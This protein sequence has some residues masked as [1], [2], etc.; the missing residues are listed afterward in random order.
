MR[1]FIFIGLVAFASICDVAVAMQNTPPHPVVTRVRPAGA[2]A[3]ARTPPTCG[4]TPAN[5]K[6]DVACLG[7]NHQQDLRDYGLQAADLVSI[8]KLIY[9]HGMRLTM[10]ELEASMNGNHETAV[11]GLPNGLIVVLNSFCPVIEAGPDTPSRVELSK[12]RLVSCLSDKLFESIILEEANSHGGFARIG[13][14][15]PN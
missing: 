6:A 13:K 4:D 9:L 1:K 10:R 14:V 11:R 5:S 3:P 2:P 8:N 7:A 15:L 12:R